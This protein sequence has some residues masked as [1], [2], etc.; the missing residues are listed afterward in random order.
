MAAA[1]YKLALLVLLCTAC[2]SIAA[3]ER[4][5]EGTE[6]QVTAIDGQTTPRSENYRVNFR[7]GQFGGRFGCNSFSG[8]YKV[9]E[10]TILA[11]DPVGATEMACEGPAM[12]FESR[13]FRVLQQPMRIDWT[14]GHHRLKLSNG[15]GSINLERAP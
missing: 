3:D 10:G 6:W 5:F 4:T 14:D 2:T 8:A 9:R 12:D 1:A 13:G 15:A 11:V 7:K